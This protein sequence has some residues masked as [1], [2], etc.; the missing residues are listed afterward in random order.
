MTEWNIYWVEWRSDTE[1][2][3]GI[4]GERNRNLE[5]ERMYRRGVDLY[6]CK[7]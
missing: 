6:E 4:N 1:V 2:A 7:E 3:I 5:E